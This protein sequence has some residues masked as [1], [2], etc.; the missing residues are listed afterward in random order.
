MYAE[1]AEARFCNAETQVMN[2]PELCAMAR[3]HATDS[4]A[5]F[6]A[7]PSTVNLGTVVISDYFL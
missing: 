1:E 4:D 6:Y 5:V 7:L 2:L 3:K